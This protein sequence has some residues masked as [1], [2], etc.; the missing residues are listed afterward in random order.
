M[1]S[2]PLE[3]VFKSINF[4]SNLLGISLIIQSKSRFINMTYRS[5]T[6][7]LLTLATISLYFSIIN[8]PQLS[9]DYPI[10]HSVNWIRRIFGFITI[11]SL[12]W[13]ALVYS[14][15]K[16]KIISILN[17]VNGMFSTQFDIQ[18]SYRKIYWIING[19]LL[20]IFIFLFGL[21]GLMCWHYE[22]SDYEWIA[23]EYLV[24]MHP[25]VLM[26]LNQ[27]KVIHVISIINSKFNGLNVILL[28]WD[29]FDKKIRAASRKIFK[30]KEVQVATNSMIIV[31]Y[32]DL[33]KIAEI[34]EMLFEAIELINKV[35][36]LSNLT[37]ISF[38]S[39]SLIGQILLLA[40]ILHFDGIFHLTREL[41]SNF[42]LLIF[43]NYIIFVFNSYRSMDLSFSCIY[44]LYYNNMPFNCCK[45]KNS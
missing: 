35:F 24:G 6:I 15:E 17:Q 8:V 10:P 25:T 3:S 34:Y 16:L 12:F 45:G 1:N 13:Q 33:K 18:F 44:W 42:F 23:F 41:L 7:V 28:E 9:L 38:V 11:A 29:R 14:T 39:V 43:L 4:I 31:Q 22:L 27:L 26:C 30:I 32:G 5:Y 37:S 21:F 36:G 40:R 20:L 19:Q 2:L